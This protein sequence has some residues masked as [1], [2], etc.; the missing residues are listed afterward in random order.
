MRWCGLVYSCNAAAASI[1]GKHANGMRRIARSNVELCPLCYVGLDARAR[2]Q[3]DITC[4]AISSIPRLQISLDGSP[5]IDK[6]RPLAWGWTKMTER[7]MP[8]IP[9]LGPRH[10]GR[11]AECRPTWG[12]VLQCRRTAV[13]STCGACHHSPCRRRASG[14]TLCSAWN[15]SE[16]TMDAGR[17]RCGRVC[18]GRGVRGP[19]AS[20]VGH[21]PHHWNQSRTHRMRR[22]GCQ[23][24][25]CAHTGACRAC[26]TPPEIG[27]QG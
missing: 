26:G 9:T 23:P 12:G 17:E 24:R 13:L 4:R 2:G 25:R 11:H 8:K 1:T 22:T 19:N 15:W 14:P 27:R 6:D 21:A 18:E 5:D 20:G 7:H 16:H 3:S 10:R